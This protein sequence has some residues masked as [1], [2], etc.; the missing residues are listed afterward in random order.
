M[1]APPISVGRAVSTR[2]PKVLVKADAK[3]SADSVP[4]SAQLNPPVALLEKVP[5]EE[6]IKVAK[7][8]SKSNKTDYFC[9][10][11]GNARSRLHILVLRNNRGHCQIVSFCPSL[12]SSHHRSVSLG[13]NVG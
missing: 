1:K 7:K 13:V 12:T 9:I 8:M 11:R 4:N 5:A 3:N 2:N 10:R 6:L